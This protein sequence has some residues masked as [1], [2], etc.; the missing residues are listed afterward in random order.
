MTTWA[1]RRKS[2]YALLVMLAIVVLIGLPL[3]KIFY[4]APS[5]FDSRQNGD[6]TGVDCGGSCRKLCQSAFLPP[7]I[8]WGGAKMEKIN[9][10]FYNVSSYIVNPNIYG[11]VINAPYKI[12]LYD[13]EGVLITERQG[14]VTLYPRRN[15]LAFQTAIR[16]DERIP[17][18]ATFEFT[19]PPQWFKSSDRLAGISIIDKKYKEDEDGSSLEVTLE[20][21][22]LLPFR[23]V[24]ISVVLYDIHANVIGFSQTRVDSIA[25]HSREIA[26]FTWP[27]SREGKVTSIEVIPI[28]SPLMTL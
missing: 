26:P 20:N 14:S 18:K 9:K 25:A 16:T 19:S 8:E 27:I 11:A 10:G 1:S 6:E 21:T 15:S 17:A 12:S 24:L 7:R 5:C 3:F 23:D 13:S 2:T 28:I 22:N 4:K